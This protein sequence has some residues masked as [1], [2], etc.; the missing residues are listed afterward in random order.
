MDSA[1]LSR[2]PFRHSWPV[3]PHASIGFRGACWAPWVR[4]NR[5]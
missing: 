4:S 1:Q 2:T 3:S 5:R